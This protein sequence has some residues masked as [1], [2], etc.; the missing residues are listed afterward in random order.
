MSTS[1]P[2][3]D[4]PEL[5]SE[6]LD[7][8]EKPPEPLAPSPQALGVWELAW[9]TIVAGALQTLVRWV[10]LKMVGDLG[11][12]AVAGVAAGGHV[13]WLIQSI[14]M[15]VTTGIVALVARAVGA[16]DDA[17][18]DATLRQGMVLGTLFGV[19]TFAAA[20]PFTSWAIAIYGVDQGV[21][22]NG[23][24]YLA[25]LLVGNVP[26][27]LTFVFGS[28]LRAAGDVRTPLYVGGV[29]NL[30]N[31]FLNWVLIYGNLGAPA[32]GV[33]G[34]A[35]ASSGAMLFQVVV[36][37]ILWQ[38]NSLQLRPGGGSFRP[39]LALWR[40]LLHIGYPAALEGGL[41]HV[42][43]LMFLRIVSGY[44]TAA[45]TAYQIGA[46]VLSLAFLAGS[47]FAMAASTLVGQHLGDRQPEQ[48][49]RSGWRSLRGSIVSMTLLGAV[50]IAMARPIARWFLD[51]EEVVALTVD[52][53]WVM[54]AV[55]PMMA[56]EFT[57]G[58]A[59]RG[60][61]DTR[62]PLVTIF[63]GLLICRL[64]PAAIAA[65]VF[66]ASVQ[67]VWCALILDYS[68]K[69]VML[70]IRFRRGAWKQIEI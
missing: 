15:A 10:D 41:W 60:A 27:T 32:L 69:A 47:G 38:R 19:V 53:I 25:W 28:A 22:E 6:L 1:P 5:A 30:L 52:F 8:R 26:F 35:L 11:V 16:R 23:S 44:G 58:G 37:W 54:G 57:L 70:V 29:A 39:D 45:F 18:A 3:D 14:V 2:P 36:F 4:R 34:A 40:R 50:L 68:V 42:G 61:G 20:L 51:D 12:E 13:Y 33:T 21:I 24:T 66:H 62:F 65:W 46:Q 17:L 64:V 31:I 55:Q 56:V 48:A 43:L 67:V 63:T 49:E 9:P 7:L 59:L